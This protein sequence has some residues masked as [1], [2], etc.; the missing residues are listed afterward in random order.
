MKYLTLHNPNVLAIKLKKV[1]SFVQLKKTLQI[2]REGW[3]FIHEKYKANKSTRTNAMKK[4]DN[5]NT[6]N[7]LIIHLNMK[8]WTFAWTKFK[9]MFLKFSKHLLQMINVISWG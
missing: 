7:T 2:K 5:Q 1:I 6:I 9:V 3:E 4:H 8:E